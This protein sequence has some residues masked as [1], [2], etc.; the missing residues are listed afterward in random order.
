MYCVL[1]PAGFHYF[2]AL[3]QS[4]LSSLTD[5][6][7]VFISRF[8]CFQKVVRNLT[9]L[10]GSRRFQSPLE[11]GFWCLLAKSS[12]RTQYLVS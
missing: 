7:W 3:L 9:W 12:H 6:V 5:R 8:V 4:V 10:P 11:S 1:K 2:P